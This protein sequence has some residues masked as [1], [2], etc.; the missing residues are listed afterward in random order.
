L[1]DV[2]WLLWLEKR[3]MDRCLGIISECLLVRDGARWG[4]MGVGAALVGAAEGGVK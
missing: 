4:M 2:D 1:V 3:E